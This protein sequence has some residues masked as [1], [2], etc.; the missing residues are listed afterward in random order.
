MLVD[1]VKAGLIYVLLIKHVKQH[2]V[3]GLGH[4]TRAIIDSRLQGLLFVD[5][6]SELKNC[7][8]ERLDLLR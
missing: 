7:L 4:V 2:V 3:L 6:I 1:Q 8:F 5:L